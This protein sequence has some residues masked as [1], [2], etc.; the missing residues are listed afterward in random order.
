MIRKYAA[1]S[2]CVL[3]L[4]ACSTVT[5]VF[6]SDK[7]K[8]EAPTRLV[9]ITS[10]IAVNKLWSVSIGEGEAELGVRQKP[11]V[12]GDLVFAADSANQLVAVDKATGKIRWKVNPNKEAETS[13]WKFW[14][15][16][17]QP[18]ALTGGPSV[19][20]GLVAIGGR[21]GEVFAFNAVDGSL[22]W[23]TMVS[24]SVISAPLVTFDTV[25]VRSNDGKVFGLDLSTGEKRWQFDRGLPTLSVRGNSSPV[26]GPGLILLGYEDG[27]LIALRQEDG[28]RVWE[29]LVA[30]PDGRTEI[31]RMADI[32]G[33]IQVGD[34]EVFASSYRNSTMAI[35][36]N[37]GQPI[38]AREVGGSAGVA[39]LS[40]RIIV[41]DRQSNVVA[42]DRNG[43]SDLW[44]QQGLVR[45]GLT[46]AVV[47]GAY[48]VLA[49]KEGYVHW[50]DSNTGDIKGRMSAGKSV[51]GS[52]VVSDD[53][54][55]FVQSTDGKLTAFGLAQ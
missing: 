19:Y 45:R 14:K 41:V 28:T 16:S 13:G 34:R 29:Q 55:V 2:L 3:L 23:K 17:T 20:S 39:M 15:K 47:Q 38:W 53:G 26:L 31:D 12:D 25:I 18:F 36:L 32:D 33:E 4:S 46:T 50:L 51:R 8:A 7:E 21:N 37:N 30:K 43:G 24:S 42:L 54:I 22:L 44:K 5:N 52:P 10:P 1:L 27:T 48:L 49:D 40:D 9:E 35:S 6:K 11:V